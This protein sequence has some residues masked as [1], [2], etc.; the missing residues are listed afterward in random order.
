MLGVIGIP[1][2]TVLYAGPPIGKGPI[3]STSGMSG[4]A[5]GSNPV[6]VDFSLTKASDFLVDSTGTIFV[7]VL[8]TSG[9]LIAG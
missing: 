9:K 8:R 2:D 5:L 3:S 6:D 1:G 4:V 7:S